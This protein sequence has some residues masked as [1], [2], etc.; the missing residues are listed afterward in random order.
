MT[1]QKLKP[2]LNLFDATVLVIGSVIGSGIFLTTGHIAAHIP[3][4]LWIMLVW[5]LGAVITLFGGLTF[6]ELGT[7]IPE[8][9]GQY[10][11]LR[12]SYGPFAGFLYG[13]TT[14]LVTQTGG[15]AALG[16]GFAEYLSF[17]FPTLGLDQY[18]IMGTWIPVS[19][20]QLVALSSIILLTGVN[21]FGIRSG[22]WVQN[23]FTLIKILTLTILVIV[24]LFFAA[25]SE[26]ITSGSQVNDFSPRMGMISAIGI[27]LIAVLWTFDGWYS[28]NIVASEIKNVKRNLPVSLILGI[29]LTGVIYLAVNWFYLK[30]LPLM[31]LVNV[32]RVGEKATSFLFNETAGSAMSALILVSIFGCLSATVIYGP[33]IFYAM[34][35]DGQFFK[36]FSRVHPKYHSPYIAVVGQGIWAGL[37]CL[38]GT[39]EQLYTY[40]VFVLLFFYIATAAAVIVLRKKQPELERPYKVWGYP[41][42]PALFALSMMWIMLN[43][44]VEKPTESIIG[45]FLVLT[46][47]PVYFYWHKRNN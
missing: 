16:V 8:A 40:V 41:V 47:I 23:I 39:Y 30:A 21:Y 45:I 31:E 32:L 5:L 34:A 26:T 38:T 2:Q 43:T 28:V 1:T 3:D 12:E 11:Y 18:S 36:S 27:A 20:G 7:M 29:G 6:A 24:G 37:L 17:F 22:N 13:W 9:G 25:G 35:S 42:V 33:R 14:I 10:A 44:V 46:G 15:I 19:N 4:P